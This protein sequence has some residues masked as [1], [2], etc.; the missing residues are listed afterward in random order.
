MRLRPEEVVTIKAAVVQTFGDGA[1]VRLFG[2]RTDDAR[3]GGDI[4]L[5]VEVAPGADWFD[6]S[7]RLR[8]LLFMDLEREVDVVVERRGEPMRLID[9]VAKRHGIVL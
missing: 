9:R 5:H 8:S 1:V 7:I 3:R 4:D 6:R 2:S